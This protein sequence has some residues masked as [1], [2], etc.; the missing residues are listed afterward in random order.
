VGYRHNYALHAFQA[1]QWKTFN[2]QLPL[3]SGGTNYA[4]FG[5]KQRFDEMVAQAAKK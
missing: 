5:G 2:R 1:E 4:Y 3:F